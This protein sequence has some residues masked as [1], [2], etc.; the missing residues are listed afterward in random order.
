[1]DAVAAFQ[2]YRYIYAAWLAA[3]VVWLVGALAAKPAARTQS[4]ASRIFHTLLLGLAILLWTRA[5][6]RIPFLM[7]KFLPPAPAIAY[8]GAI[9][10]VAGIAIAIWA[11]FFLGGN[12][13]ARVTIKKDHT[14]VRTGPYSFVRHPIYAGF[15]LA[16]AGTAVAI[17]EI[18][19]LLAV[20]LV[21]IALKLKANLEEQFMMQQFGEQ[22]AQY[23]RKVK[24]LIPFVW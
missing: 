23:R 1:M 24:S 19:G 15:L 6:L 12:W 8:A 21:L 20:A 4:A 10:T 5:S 14:L 17:G 9:L 11:R 2:P 7:Q 13:S 3:G 18:R 16:L 22:Y